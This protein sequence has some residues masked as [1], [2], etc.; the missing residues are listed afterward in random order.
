MLMLW[1]NKKENRLL[2]GRGVAYHLKHS[3]QW[4][5]TEKM[6]SD[7]TQKRKAVSQV[8]YLRTRTPD[9]RASRHKSPKVRIC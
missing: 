4:K 1:R 5:P 7:Q 9:T 2:Q 3:G 6:V 8:K